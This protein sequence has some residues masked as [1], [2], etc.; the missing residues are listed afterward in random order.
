MN[1]ADMTKKRIDSTIVHFSV[2]DVFDSLITSSDNCNPLFSHTSL[3]V[4]KEIVLNYGAEIDL[5]VFY[6]SVVGGRARSLIE[7][8]SFIQDCHALGGAIRFAPHALDYYH[9]PFEQTPEQQI[10]SF[11]KIYTQID[12]FA[13]S[14]MRSS[15]IRLH[16]YSESYELADYFKEKR[17]RTLFTTDREIGSHRMPSSVSKELLKNGVS[18]YFG[19]RFERTQYRL[20]FMVESGISEAEVKNLCKKSIEQF[21]RVVVYTHECELARPLIRKMLVTIYSACDEIINKGVK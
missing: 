12:R 16:Y 4:L 8:S 7:V 11:E 19:Q 17:V 21:G 6:R 1:I 9:Y 3:E 15:E 13:G 2:D 14:K 18:T 10:E 5:Y 20:E